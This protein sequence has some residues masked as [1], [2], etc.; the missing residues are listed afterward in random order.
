MT[1]IVLL[2]VSIISGQ[3]VLIVGT[4]FSFAFFYLMYGW[5][6]VREKKAKLIKRGGIKEVTGQ[7]AMQWGYAQIGVAVI[8]LSIGVYLL[9][10]W[11]NV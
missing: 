11:L 8:L 6:S 5:N 3:F 2:I 7:K 4:I 9:L 10:R 1:S